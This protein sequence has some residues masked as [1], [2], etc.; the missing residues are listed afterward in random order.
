MQRLRSSRISADEVPNRLT[1][2]DR[3]LDAFVGRTGAL[4]SYVQRSTRAMPVDQ[5]QALVTDG[6]KAQCVALAFTGRSLV[7]AS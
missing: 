1:V 6:K 7:D 5:R 4:L 2:V 3:I